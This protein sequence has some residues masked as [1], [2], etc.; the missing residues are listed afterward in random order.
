[1]TIVIFREEVLGKLLLCYDAMVNMA[2]L[3]DLRG[4]HDVIAGRG[5]GS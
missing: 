3:W 4:Y 1:M 5:W 2:E